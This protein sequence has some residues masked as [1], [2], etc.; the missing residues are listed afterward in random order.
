M[1]KI[2]NTY[3]KFE[4]RFKLEFIS[5]P[6]GLQVDDNYIMIIGDYIDRRIELIKSGK[7]YLFL[8]SKTGILLRKNNLTITER[9]HDFII[10]NNLIICVLCKK[11]NRE[12]LYNLVKI[13][14]I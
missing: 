7:K 14:F 3:F 5:N 6:A 4:S 1:I 12:K 8:Y 10:S 13:K 2:Y 11:I 9:I